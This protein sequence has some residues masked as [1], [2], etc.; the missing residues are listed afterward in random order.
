[1]LKFTIPIRDGRF[2]VPIKLVTS[3]FTNI[4]SLHERLIWQLPVLKDNQLLLSRPNSNFAQHSFWQHGL[5]M[6]WQSWNKSRTVP[7]R[8]DQNWFKSDSN[9]HKQHSSKIASDMSRCPRKS[10]NSKLHCLV[11]LWNNRLLV[12]FNHREFSICGDS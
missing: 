9:L 10:C 6:S 8:E 11:P 7:N 2:K 5:H 12:W 3:T 4:W 1:M